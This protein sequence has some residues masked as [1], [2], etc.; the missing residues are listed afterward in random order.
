MFRLKFFVA[1]LSTF[2]LFV[3]GCFHQPSDKSATAALN[4]IKLDFSRFKTVDQASA[5]FGGEPIGQEGVSHTWQVQ[6][7]LTMTFQIAKA[8]FVRSGKE[9]NPTP[10]FDPPIADINQAEAAFGRKPDRTITNELLE[11]TVASFAVDGRYEISFGFMKDGSTSV[12][13][14]GSE[15][16]KAAVDKVIVLQ[17]DTV[18]AP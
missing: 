2:A 8:G 16:A 5:L 18:A 4:A 7:G 14:S 9:T 17:D 3:A 15:A 11:M 12:L 6:E 10:T 1:S 13:I